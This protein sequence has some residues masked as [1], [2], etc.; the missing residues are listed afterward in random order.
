MSPWVRDRL[1]GLK[2]RTE[3]SEILD[4]SPDCCPVCQSVKIVFATGHGCAYTIYQNLLWSGNKETQLSC[5]QIF[6][7]NF[8]YLT[9]AGSLPLENGAGAGVITGQ[10]FFSQWSEWEPLPSVLPPKGTRD[11]CPCKTVGLI[12]W[13]WIQCLTAPFYSS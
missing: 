1:A 12:L 7:S 5:R 13:M 9:R 2:E 10:I 4:L 11:K 6:C 3:R 8:I